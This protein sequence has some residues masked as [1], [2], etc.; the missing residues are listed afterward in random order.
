MSDSKPKAPVIPAGL[1]SRLRGL[2]G[3]VVYNLASLGFLAVAG[4]VLNLIIGRVYGAGILGIFSIVFAIYIFAS[5]IGT[6]GI[7]YSVLRAMS[8]ASDTEQAR[9]AAYSAL[10]LVTITST[11]A[12]LAAW[13][14]LPLLHRIYP[15]AGLDIAYLIALPG[16]WC[17]SLNKVLL[18]IVNGQSHMRAFAVLQAARYVFMLLTFIVILAANVRG[19]YITMTLTAAEVLLLVVSAGYVRGCL[20]HWSGLSDTRT[21]VA[22]HARFGARAMPSGLVTELNTR[23]DVLLLGSMLGEVQTGIYSTAIML[24]EGL[25]QVV[26]VVR[27]VINPSLSKVVVAH[28]QAALRSLF[29]GAGLGTLGLTLAG[30]IA[31]CGVFGYGYQWLLGD[32]FAAALLPLIVLVSAITVSSPFMAFSMILMQGGQPATSSIFMTMVLVANMVFTF[33]GIQAAGIDGAATGTG[34]SFVFA[35]TLLVIMVRRSFG[36]RL[37]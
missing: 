1:A 4:L 22:E 13:L 12:T 5:Q 31:L 34:L 17:F 28:D 30:A 15:I 14:C 23:V 6:A 16:L 21:W 7:H 26:V 36:L 9:A 18:S 24:A 32:Q 27:N 2:S 8:L 25:F 37:V 35:A 33:V 10:L 29:L 19:E 3:D 20:G 11:L